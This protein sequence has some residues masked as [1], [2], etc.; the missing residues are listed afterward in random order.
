MRFKN[1]LFIDDDEDDLELVRNAME[2][3]SDVKSYNTLNNPLTALIKLENKEL[4][5]DLIVLDLNMPVMS[6]FQ[7]L[8]KI[9]K[10]PGLRAI[11]VVILSTTSNP[12]A[13]EKAKTLGALNFYTKPMRFIAL[14]D[15]IRSMLVKVKE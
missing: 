13:K 15:L 3:I 12:L 6:G 11:P 14:I 7:F 10:N 2:A 9:K 8:E 4:T 5:P 1:L